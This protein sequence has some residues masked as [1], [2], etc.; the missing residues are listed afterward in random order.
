MDSIVCDGQSCHISPKAMEVLLCL[1]RHPGRVVGKDEIFN[2]VWKETFVSDDSLTRCIGELRRAF[3]DGAHEP[4]VIRTI[5]KRGYLLLLPVVWNE[6]NLSPQPVLNTEALAATQN[7]EM[8]RSLSPSAGAEPQPAA[9]APEPARAMPRLL[10]PAGVCAVLL[11][12]I[13]WPMIARMERNRHYAPNNIHTIA[14]LPLANLSADP[15]Q[16]YFADGMTEE[17][18]TEL[19]QLKTCDVTSRTSVMRYKGSKQPLREIARELSAEAVIEGTVLRSGTRVRITAQLI[20]AATDKHIWS[21][22]FEGEM[23]DVFALQASI[24]RAITAELNLSL[25]PQNQDRSK[26]GRKVIPE[27]YDAYLRG[28]YFFDRAQYSKAASYFEQSTVADPSF[29]MAHALLFE[30]DAMTSY[31]QDQQLSERALKTMARA[32]QLDDNLAE[33]RDAVADVASVGN[34]NWEAGEAGYRAATE[35]DPSS[36]EAALH[37]VYSLHSL[38]R[39]Q[40]AT[41]ELQRALRLAPVSPAVNLEKLRLLVDTHQYDAALQ[42]FRKVI[43]LDPASVGA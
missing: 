24:A 29:A 13:V 9:S 10:L 43:E 7:Q 41:L 42:Q 31:V 14:V 27:A 25:S 11:A 23:A 20:D 33:T 35:L 37:Y 17:L 28:W 1:A 5:A 21:G 30:A 22:S 6:N 3:Q 26:T 38:C 12:A 39:W 36:V 19:A 18:I 15:E 8:P 34:W 40:A 32:R 16:E 4:R 2:E